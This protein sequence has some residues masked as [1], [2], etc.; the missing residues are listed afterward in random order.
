MERRCVRERRRQR[1]ARVITASTVLALSACGVPVTNSNNAPNAENKPSLSGMGIASEQCASCHAI[2]RKGASPHPDALE[3]R[4]FSK[5]YPIEHL[6]EALA[7]GI[8]VGH[9]DMQIGRAACW[10]R[11]SSPLSISGVAVTLNKEIV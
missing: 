7:E 5:F 3:F 11:V 1:L 9:P 2:G 4:N 8:I 10:E 6:G